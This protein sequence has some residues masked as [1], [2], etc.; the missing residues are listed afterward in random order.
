[1]RA[2]RYRLALCDD[3]ATCHPT[4]KLILGD[5]F[6]VLSAETPWELHNLM[7]NVSVDAVLLDLRFDGPRDGF[8][9][10]T[11]LRRDRRHIPVLIYS[12]S[13]EYE[14]IVDAMRLGAYDYIQKGLHPPS[15]VRRKILDA[16]DC[17]SHTRHNDIRMVGDSTAL[18]ELRKNISLIRDAPGNVIIH[19]ETGV[20]KELVA[21]SLRRRIPYTDAEPF[22]AVNSSTI[23]RDTAESFL[24][25]HERGAFTGA[26]VPK[27]GAFEQADGGIIYFDEIDKM[28]LDIQAKLLRVLQ[29][30]E[31]VRL[32]SVH[33]RSADFR[34]VCATN[35]DL[36]ALCTNG[37]FRSDLLAR[38]EVFPLNVVPLRERAE[39]IEPLARYFLERHTPPGRRL[40]FSDEVIAKFLS[41]DWPQNVRQLSNAIQHAVTMCREHTITLKHIPKKI[42]A[43]AKREESFDSCSHKS[44][45]NSLGYHQAPVQDEACTYHEAMKRFERRFFLETLARTQGNISAAAREIRLS[46][47][48]LYEKLQKHGITNVRGVVP[49]LRAT[50]GEAGS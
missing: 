23:H 47:T 40:T 41:Y 13:D 35:R 46:R 2:P 42:C 39:D 20:G 44:I 14:A 25:G 10:L 30:K 5:E 32:G 36:D 8:D 24:F 43:C 12:G 18:R 49:A 11:R 1:M 7:S 38:L 3:D 29:E 33:P 28:D 6:D 48:H 9:A 26:T 19:G 34:V 31:V 15:K 17:H 37:E 27:K 21:Q 50:C 22:V 45:L 16:I 4:V